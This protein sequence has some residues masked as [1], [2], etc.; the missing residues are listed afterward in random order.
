MRLNGEASVAL[1]VKRRSAKIQLSRPIKVGFLWQPP[2]R[3]SCRAV[4]PA[5]M[6]L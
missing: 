2:R 5:I 3:A 4:R 6:N 1:I